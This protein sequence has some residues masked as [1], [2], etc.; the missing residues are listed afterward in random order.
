MKR[1]LKIL[2]AAVVLT[3]AGPGRVAAQKV[4]GEDLIID[5]SDFIDDIPRFHQ[6]HSAQS[7]GIDWVWSLDVDWLYNNF[8][9]KFVTKVGFSNSN[10]MKDVVIPGEGVYYLYVRSVGGG[11]NTFRLRVNDRFVDTVFG[12]GEEGA[13]M[14]Q[15]GSYTFS[16]GEKVHLTITR[17]T[18]SPA[19]DVIVFSKNPNLTEDDLKASQFPDEVALLHE[20]DIPSSRCVKFGDL[21]GDGKTDFVVLGD[22]YSSYA[23]DNSG[24]ELWR[25]V[26]PPADAAA[27]EVE[28][29]IP[30][31]VWDF[32]RDGKAEFVC[33]REM[34]GK[35]WLVV[36]DGMSGA[37][38]ARTEWPT[39]PRPHVYNNFRIAIGNLDGSYPTGILVFTDDG[40]GLS[41][42]AYTP[43]LAPLWSY[44]GQLRKDHLGHYV[45]PRDFNG[46]GIDE[47]L[48][49]Y[50][51]F[52]HRG[53]VIWERLS[54]VF[55][56]NDHVD[57][58][59]FADLNGDGR[60]EIISATSALGTQARDAMTGR[61]MWESPSEH[62]QQ[63]QAGMFLEGYDRPQ[64]V[65][66]ARVYKD[67][68]VDPYI[69]MQLYWFDHTGRLIRRWPANEL[70]GNPDF[71]SGD[72][73]GN[74]TEKLFWGRFGLLP[75][76]RGQLYFP[77]NI[78]HGFDFERNGAFQVITLERTKLKVWG[79]R[80]A[81]AR[82]ANNDPDY[83][84][85]T[86]T[87]HT[88]Y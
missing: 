8:A 11:R 9:I 13:V 61:L 52:D 78:Y 76:G 35:E 59:Q 51:M 66:G 62:N 49:G 24:R 75:D 15:A 53:N 82:P 68:A 42:H 23:F 14:V 45:Y 16:R 3:T 64:V 67:R 65:A 6:I 25:W 43:K 34:D 37:V 56:N 31:A 17:A 39:G 50:L 74:G 38:K 85:H 5:A 7:M 2:M 10:Y 71:T 81:T 44:S 86:M 84:R 18:G 55:D 80:H 26:S 88:H 21:T 46:D 28:D 19:L 33:W 40:S 60:E 73:Y 58:Y 87:N 70:N 12:Q 54:D 22:D 27:R 30:G 20:Y 83:L 4:V 29:E 63:V 32:D 48:C 47:V 57:T 69:S 79:Y 41:L 36:V 1:Y 77:G 72:W